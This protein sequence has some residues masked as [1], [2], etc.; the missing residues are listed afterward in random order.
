M[1]ILA[2]LRERVGRAFSDGSGL[3]E[4]VWELFR[5]RRWL[6]QEALGLEALLAGP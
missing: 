6:P 4:P 2:G 5:R 3:L 1:E